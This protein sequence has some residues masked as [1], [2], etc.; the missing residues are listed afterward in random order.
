[1]DAPARVLAEA[2]DAY[3]GPWNFWNGVRA[4][5]STLAFVALIGACVLRE[6]RGPRGKSSP[7]SEGRFLR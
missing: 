1:P 2:R 6:D 5:F 4:V 3:E 7:A